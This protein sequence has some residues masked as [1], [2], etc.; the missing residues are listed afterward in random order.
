MAY[1]RN[2]VLH[3]RVSLE[4]FVKGVSLL[5]HEES[6][7]FTT[8]FNIP[9]PKS[10]VH[11]Y[12]LFV[13]YHI[14][15]GN[16]PIPSGGNPMVRNTA[17]RGPIFL[18]WHRQMILALEAHIQRVLSDTTFRL[19]YWDWSADGDNGSPTNALIWTPAYMGGQGSPVS[20][21]PFAS[22]SG[23]TVR[24]DGATGMP[25]QTAR[26]LSREFAQPWPDGLPTL[27]TSTDVKSTLDFTPAGPQPK[28]VDRYDTLTFDVDSEGFRNR[29]EGF[30]PYHFDQP[31]RMHN[32]VHLWVGGDMIP[33]SSPT[34]RCS[35]CTTAT[36]TESGKRG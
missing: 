12:D 32:Q 34:I 17:H 2:N 19:P 21:G 22:G 20:D 29:L 27:P 10:P 3:D 5:K 26:G 6:G 14:R 33:M 8:D 7:R 13:L 28:P 24:I 11:T 31:V 16:A 35:T 36:W 25:S 4:K 1:T 15:M 23:F 9:G 18:P 30:L